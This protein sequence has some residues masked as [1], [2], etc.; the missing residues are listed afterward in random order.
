MR[1]G[2]DRKYSAEKNGEAPSNEDAIS[3]LSPEVM[4]AH[5]VLENAA[6][7]EGNTADRNSSQTVKVKQPNFILST[8]PVG[9]KWTACLKREAA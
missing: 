9:S 5:T 8:F 2:G 4:Y 1:R 7:G 6:R 3:T